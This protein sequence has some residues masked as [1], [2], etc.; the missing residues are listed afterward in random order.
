MISSFLNTYGI[1]VY[2]SPLRQVLTGR[3]KLK[4]LVLA[5]AVT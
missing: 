4:V 3:E 5:S 1:D 2:L